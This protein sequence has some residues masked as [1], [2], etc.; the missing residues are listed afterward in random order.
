MQAHEFRK[1]LIMTPRNLLAPTSIA[2]TAALLALSACGKGSEQPASQVAAKVNKGEISVHQINFQLARAGNIPPEQAKVASQQVLE[3]LI[4]QD[5]LVEK[6]VEGKLDRDP[7]V[8]TTVENA[9]RQ[10]LAQAY[11]EKVMAAAGKPDAK[12]ISEYFAQHPELFTKRR[13]FKIQE[14]DIRMEPALV[15]E[16]QQDIGKGKSI[17]DVAAW[18]KT[19][20]LPANAGIWVKPAEQLPLAMLPR[21]NE[22]KDGQMALIAQPSG[23]TVIQLLAS[24]DQPIDEKSATPVIEQFLFNKRKTEIAEREVKQLRQAATIEYVGEFAQKDAAKEVSKIAAPT[25]AVSPVSPAAPVNATTNPAVTPVPA[26]ANSKESDAISR[27][28]AGLK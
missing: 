17:A 26:A 15:T 22:M 20:N 19:K 24:Q 27:G 25:A 23:A 28:L 11:L 6:A 13:I 2:I 12:E 21:L 10:I 7:N 14:L 5:L 8:M 16:L 18:A 9:R 4:D 3:K 1:G